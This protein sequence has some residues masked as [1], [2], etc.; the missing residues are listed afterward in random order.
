MKKLFDEYVKTWGERTR[1]PGS[2]DYAGLRRLGY[3]PSDAAKLAAK[4]I[5]ALGRDAS[6]PAIQM[7]ID[8]ALA[9]E[10][11]ETARKLMEHLTR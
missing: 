10:R 9:E 2:V 1:T 3:T 11:A 7:C 4:A 6:E 5:K 8:S